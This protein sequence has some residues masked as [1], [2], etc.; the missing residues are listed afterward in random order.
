MSS[1]LDADDEHS[2]SF[3]CTESLIYIH[4]NLST[5]MLLIELFGAQAAWFHSLNW[6]TAE[7]SAC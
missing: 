5:K 3:Q 4:Y 1:K 7:Y 2:R 6:N